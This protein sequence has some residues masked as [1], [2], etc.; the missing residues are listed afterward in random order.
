L[1]PKDHLVVT[2]IDAPDSAR[3]TDDAN[4]PGD[5]IGVDI[6]AKAFRG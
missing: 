1:L 6:G 2:A 3:E 5:L 4:I